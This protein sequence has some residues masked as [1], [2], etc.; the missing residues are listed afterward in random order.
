MCE[1]RSHRKSAI[2]TWYSRLIARIYDPFM[3][4]MET[5]VLQ[6]RRRHL[7][8]AIEGT[9]LEI[10]AGTGINFPFYPPDVTVIATEPSPAMRSKA[11]QK[12]AGAVFPASIQL[13]PYGVEDKALEVRLPIEGVDA[14]VCTLVLCTIPDPV[15]A[16]TQF[17]RWLKPGGKLIV[18]EHLVSEKPH[19]R[20]LQHL[21]NP[22]WK[23]MAEG[24]NLNRSTDLLLRQQGFRPDWEQ[25]F[26]K[27]MRFYQA[28]GHFT[29]Q[30]DSLKSH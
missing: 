16:I 21:V 2:S 1:P 24:C 13:L 10:G 14:I 3:A 25:Y 30:P 17:Q 9:V 20:R 8:A 15:A 19:L 18:L 22:A 4:R 27:G 28:I 6:K 7:L 23:F 29:N 11:E 12:L 5:R 26:T